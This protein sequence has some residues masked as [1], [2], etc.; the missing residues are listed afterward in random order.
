MN[1]I[2]GLCGGGSRFKNVGVSLPKFLMIYNG[3]PMIYHAVETIKIPG[4]IHFVVREDQLLENKHLEKLLLGLGD[5]IIVSK[6]RTRGAAESLLLAKN[7]IKDLNAPMLSANCDQYLSWNPFNLTDQMQREPDVNFIVTYKE[8][9]PKC[10]YV[11]EQAGFVVEVREKRVISNDATIGFYHWAHTRDFFQDAEQ[12]IAEDHKENGEYYVA[13]VYNYSIQRGL[14][15]KK[16]A[17]DNAEFW[18]VGTPDDFM[19]FTGNTAFFD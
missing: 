16:Y 13:P 5:E 19:H 10:S 15:V 7:Y 3:A 8:T 11:K 1:I 12:M 9:S 2:M 4:K 14:K 17:I 18:P 6:G